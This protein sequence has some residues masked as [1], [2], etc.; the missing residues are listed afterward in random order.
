MPDEIANVRELF[1][2]GIEIV[3]VAPKEY[4]GVIPALPVGRRF[5]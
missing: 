5:S 4:P 1:F 3:I 2:D